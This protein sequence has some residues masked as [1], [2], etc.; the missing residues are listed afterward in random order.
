M[1]KLWLLLI[2]VSFVIYLL[3]MFG[4]A[5]ATYQKPD[6]TKL[7]VSRPIFASVSVGVTSANGDMVTINA[8]TSVAVDQLA[9][10]ALAGYAKYMSGG[11]MST[12]V[13]AVEPQAVLVPRA[14]Q[15]TPPPAE[16]IR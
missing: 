8:S 7:T 11:L 9:Q 12:P 10:T 14:A 5:T 16:E 2:S 13:Q 4:C 1:K 3:S 6:G 15:A